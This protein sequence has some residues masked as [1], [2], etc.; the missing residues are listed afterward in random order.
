MYKF[1]EAMRVVERELSMQAALAKTDPQPLHIPLLLGPVGCGKTAI[2]HAMAEKF[3]LPLQVINC[4]EN[5]DATDVSGLPVPGGMTA[6]D[7]PVTK[8][9]L[10]VTAANACAA[11]VLLFFD[12]LDKGPKQVQGALLSVMGARYFRDWPLHRRTLVMAAGNR[13]DDDAHASEIS[14]SLRTRVT[15][16]ELLP[17]VESFTAYGREGAIQ[18]AILGYLQHKPEHLHKPQEGVN[19]FPTPRGWQE[20]SNQ[21]TAYPDPF[22]DLLGNKSNNNWKVIVSNKLGEHVANDFWAWYTIVAKINVQELLTRGNLQVL[23]DDLSALTRYAAIYA[24]ALYLNTNG[25]SKKHTG[26]HTW[27]SEFLHKEMRIAFAIQLSASTRAALVKEL[28][29]VA[30]KIMESYVL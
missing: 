9:A 20:A 2:A 23:N 1:G 4:G 29:D 16:L 17:D 13:L 6:R 30:Q 18:P 10:N 5:A 28:P 7:I 27:V 25:V 24:V 22:E 3:E 21:M 19:R 14:E 26:L 8:W 15:I 11:P 12:D